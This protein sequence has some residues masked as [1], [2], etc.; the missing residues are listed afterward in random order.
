MRRDS[1]LQH[2][3][4]LIGIDRLL[5][6]W[7]SSRYILTNHW[8]IGHHIAASGA[9]GSRVSHLGVGQAGAHATVVRCIVG[10]AVGSSTAAIFGERDWPKI[11]WNNGMDDNG[12]DDRHQRWWKKT[13]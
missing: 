3:N 7:H 10:G 9:F 13:E 8:D 5:I 2:L 1:L 6:E 11:G 12:G 4:I